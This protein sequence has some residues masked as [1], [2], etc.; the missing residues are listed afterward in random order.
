MNKRHITIADILK[1]AE[2]D[3]A[4]GN[5][6]RDIFVDGPAYQASKTKPG[7]IEQ[8][9]ANGTVLIGHFENGQFIPEGKS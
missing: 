6:K 9:H 5:F 8:V 4:S 3:Q 2:E 7:M 1:K